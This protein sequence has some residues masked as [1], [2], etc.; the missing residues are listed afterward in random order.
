M[1]KKPSETKVIKQQ[2]MF[3]FVANTTKNKMLYSGKCDNCRIETENITTDHNPVSYKEIFDCF[4]NES[5]ILL[6]NIDIFENETNEIKLTDASL[7]LKW[8]KYHD[9][10]ARYRLLCNSCNSHFGSYGYK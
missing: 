1:S 2:K 7:A 3:F 10:M 5:N 9:K 6:D 4:F 8:L